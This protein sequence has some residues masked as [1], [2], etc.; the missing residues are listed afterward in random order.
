[1]PDQKDELISIIHEAFRGREDV[2]GV[3]NLSQSQ[4][5]TTVKVQGRGQTIKGPVTADLWRQHLQGEIQLGIVPIRLDGTCWW[6]A[7]DIDVYDMDLS[8]LEQRVRERTLPL[9]VARTKSGGAHLYLLLSEPTPASLV[10]RKLGDWAVSLGYPG[11]EIFPKQDQLAGEDDVGNWLNMPYCGALQDWD[12]CRRYAVEQGEPVA[13]DE[14]PLAINARRIDAATLEAVEPVGGPVSDGPPCLQSMALHGVPEGGRNEALFNFAVY[15]KLAHPDT[16]EDK[17][18]EYNSQFMTPPLGFQEAADIV[19]SLRRKDYVFRCDTEPLKGYCNK[20]VCRGRPFGIAASAGKNE[21]DVIVG[22]I[23]QLRTDPPVW[24]VT[25]NGVRLRMATDDLMNQYRFAKRCVEVLCYF[26]QRIKDKDWQGF[27]NERLQVAD[28]VEAPEDS[29]VVG[30]F[31]ILLDEFVSRNWRARD[32]EDILRGMPYHA[33]DGYVYFRSADL[34]N[35]LQAEGF[36]DLG[37]KDLWA[38]LRD[39]GAV[40]KQ[41]SIKGRNTKLWALPQP[42]EQDEPYTTPRTDQPDF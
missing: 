25:V 34:R 41:K 24:Y 10:R 18:N 42:D 26:P 39:Q 35:Y 23:T 27:L 36:R 16:W 1:M 33:E 15:A 40:H 38:E 7:I 9:T 32:W 2:Y 31:R 3:F 5:P 22:D 20:D 28:V 12:G 13:P 37:V 4:N 19:K 21:P 30:Q 14:V 17:V 29:S 6:G 8:A 11:V